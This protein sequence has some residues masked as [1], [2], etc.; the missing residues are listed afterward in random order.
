MGLLAEPST[1]EYCNSL[2]RRRGAK[3]EPDLHPAGQPRRQVGAHGAGG[4]D[5]GRRAAIQRGG[6]GPAAADLAVHR[7]LSR[8]VPRL[9]SVLINLRLFP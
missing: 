8:A 5:G 1:M 7:R 3:A 4:K 2:F 9:E 6:G